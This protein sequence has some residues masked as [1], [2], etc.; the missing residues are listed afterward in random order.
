MNIMLE[1][2]LAILGEIARGYMY[3]EGGDN[4][5]KTQISNSFPH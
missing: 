3:G 1:I 2:I 5:R 4:S